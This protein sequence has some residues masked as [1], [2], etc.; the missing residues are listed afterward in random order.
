VDP[1]VTE[2]DGDI[3]DI[4]YIIDS[5]ALNVQGLVPPN[6]YLPNAGVHTV[7]LASNPDLEIE[8]DVVDLSNGKKPQWI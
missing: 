2:V 6:A 8:Y 5:G 7:T 4:T 3:G 1:T